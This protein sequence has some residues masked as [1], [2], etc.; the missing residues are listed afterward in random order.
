MPTY[1]F[2]FSSDLACRIANCIT[3]DIELLAKTV[4]GVTVNWQTR[5]ETP[6]KAHFAEWLLREYPQH[7]DA[8]E[9]AVPAME[10]RA[11]AY[12][13]RPNKQGKPMTEFINSSDANPGYN[14]P[15]V[16]KNVPIPGE[17]YRVEPEPSHDEQEAYNAEQDSKP[18][19]K[20]EPANVK[21]K[22]AASNDA[23]AQVLREALGVGSMDSE[24]VR[25]LVREELRGIN[26]PQ[27][28]VVSSDNGEREPVNVGVQHN[29]FPELLK[30]AS[31]KGS[32][33]YSYPILLPGPAGSGKTRAAMAV[34]Q[35]LGVP[36]YHVGAVDTEYKVLGYRGA[37]GARVETEC[38]RSYGVPSVL[39]MD[40]LDAGSPQAL[41]ALC[42]M[43]ENGQ[44]DF[45]GERITRHTDNIIIATANTW[46]N[47][48]T[49]DY[50]GRN[51]LD[52]ATTDRFVMMDWAY[53]ES[54]ERALAGN[55]LWTNKVQRIRKAIVT[56]GDVKHVVSPRASIRGAALLRAGFSEAQCLNMLVWKGLTEEQI[57]RIRQHANV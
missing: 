15:G 36:Y 43:L 50:V 25:E 33:G 34:A 5:F 35:A 18:V 4:C 52:K 45:A 56:S 44:C 54:F 8:L 40:E 10:Q 38:S 14:K 23:L 3:S 9:Q 11:A 17:S 26:L 48:A 28:I 6:R 39:L 13:A 20:A 51:K 27:Q 46:G 31:T 21:P 1:N 2:S 42:M 24:A 53:D 49:H 41:V 7:R 37:T 22:H 47:G 29:Q 55:D 16:R 19:A 30:L 32:D 12:K 57:A